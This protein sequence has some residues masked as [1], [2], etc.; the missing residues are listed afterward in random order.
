MVASVCLALAVW[1]ISIGVAYL[2]AAPTADV[3]QAWQTSRSVSR[4][5]QWEWVFE[6]LHIARRLNRLRAD[7]PGDIARL[8]MWQALAFPVDSP[9]SRVHRVHAA[10]YYR[11]ALAHRPTW[12]LAWLNAAE[13]HIMLAGID[14]NAAQAF[15][16]GNQVAPW[17]P[18]VQSRTIWMGLA[19]W[20][21]LPGALRREVTGAVSRSLAINHDVTTTVRLAVQYGWI[22]RL[23]PMLLTDAQ[24]DVLSLVERQMGA[25]ARNR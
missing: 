5:E 17:E 9:E 8:H 10:A 7:Y 18:G 23:R 11:E 15:G 14:S 20:E 6:R 12:G 22:D 16:R 3:L 24:R 21:V 4:V 13:N 2:G 25:G 1:T 19:M